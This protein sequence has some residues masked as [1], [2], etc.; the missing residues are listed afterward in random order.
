MKRS[1]VLSIPLQLVFLALGIQQVVKTHLRFQKG[2]APAPNKLP[3][4]AFVEKNG[5]THDMANNGTS[6][7]KRFTAIIH[8]VL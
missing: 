2:L 3:R 5:L 7:S 4:F 6:I 1:T 8:C